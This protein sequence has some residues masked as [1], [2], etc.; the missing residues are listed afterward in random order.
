MSG[1]AL[2]RMLIEQ[3]PGLGVLYMTGY[4][5]ELL[6]PDSGLGDWAR[7]I[8]KPHNTDELLRTLNELLA[9]RQEHQ[10]RH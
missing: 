7:L 8:L 4:G 1:P 2:A 3:D 5:P 6:E 10:G 9:R